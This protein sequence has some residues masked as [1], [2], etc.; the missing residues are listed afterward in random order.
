MANIRDLNVLFWNARGL[1]NKFSELIDFIKSED[2]DIVGVNETFLDDTVNLSH[3]QGYE[4]IRLDNTNHSGGLLFIIKTTINYSAIDCPTTELFECTAL[5]IG[6]SRPFILYLVYCRGGPN[7]LISS[8]YHRELTS[9]CINQSLPVFIMGDFNAKHRAWNCVRNNKA[10]IILKNFLDQSRYFLCYPPDHTYNPISRLMTPST[11]DL[12]ITDGSISC[13]PLQVCE[14]LT[15]DHYPVK[16]DIHCSHNPLARIKNEFYNYSQ[17]DWGAF[18]SKLVDLI[19][20]TFN[21]MNHREH[22]DNTTIDE[23]INFITNATK[24]AAEITIPKYSNAKSEFVIT[25]ELRA[26]ITERN[27]F[28]RRFT[29]TRHPMDELKFKELKFRVSE[30]ICEAKRSRLDKILLECNY[31]HNNIFKVIKT[32]RHV[33]LPALRPTATNQ[34]MITS[35]KGKADE[36]ANTFAKNHINSL[37]DNLKS[38]TIKVN[39]T[40]KNFLN[41]TASTHTPTVQIEEVI[42]ILRNSKSGKASGLDNVNIIIQYLHLNSLY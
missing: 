35:R 18:R 10:G 17:A 25:P 6:A 1:R 30:C 28:R 3:V 29:R 39:K 11:I 42:D 13:S 33:N 31:K 14:I 22:I 27:Y 19:E 34:R 32:K 24:E 37:K 36:L 7:T 21:E 23:L 15:S 38:H 12:L 20:P 8:N 4:I 26:L 16:F 41:S 5:R 9:L 2:L 40:V